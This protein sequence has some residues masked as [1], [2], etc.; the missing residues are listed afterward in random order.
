M[1]AGHLEFENDLAV[2]VVDSGV[3]ELFRKLSGASERWL[4]RLLE[5]DAEIG[6]K[7]HV[8]VG[9]HRSGQREE[10]TLTFPPERAAEGNELVDALVE[11]GATRKG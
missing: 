9:W 3:L 6:K 10:G 1:V 2:V 4:V 11:G 7:G 5:V 8:E